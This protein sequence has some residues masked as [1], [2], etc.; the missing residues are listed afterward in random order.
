[1]RSFTT[2]FTQHYSATLL[3]AIVLFFVSSCCP[4]DPVFCLDVSSVSAR[5]TDAFNYDLAPSEEIP[6][7]DVYLNTSFTYSSMMCK[8]GGNALLRSPTCEG[9]R[10]YQVNIA[11]LEIT[12]DQDYQA[13]FPA[14]TDLKSLFDLF[15]LEEACFEDN[16]PLENCLLEMHTSADEFYSEINLFLGLQ[17]EDVDR[18]DRTSLFL[19]SPR[20]GP[21]KVED[22]TFSIQIQTTD[23][24]TFQRT[25]GQIRITP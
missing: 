6:F 7:Q 13:G 2:T 19:F 5:N 17:E 25:G 8:E 22:I 23:G 16:R 20:E 11:G 18:G 3:I 21:D 12:A 9:G 24:S 1:M 4:E 10:N 15:I 14:G